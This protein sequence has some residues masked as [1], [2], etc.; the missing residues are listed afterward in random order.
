[1]FASS[2]YSDERTCVE[3]LTQ[4]LCAVNSR[5]GVRGA[6]SCSPVQLCADV[7]CVSALAFRL[8]VE[9]SKSLAGCDCCHHRYDDVSLWLGGCIGAMPS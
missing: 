8:K 1:M 2:A 9:L 6:A 5:T 7:A 4:V 3:Q